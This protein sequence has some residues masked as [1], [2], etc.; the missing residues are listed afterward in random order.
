MN[1]KALLRPQI[2]IAPKYFHFFFFILGIEPWLNKTSACDKILANKAKKREAKS[3]EGDLNQGTQK[4]PGTRQQDSSQQYVEPGEESVA[5]SYDSYTGLYSN[6]GY[7]NMSVFESNGSL[8]M[9]YGK[10]NWV[11]QL[12]EWETTNTTFTAIGLDPIWY[13]NRI[14]TFQFTDPE[15]PKAQALTARFEWELD[16]VFRKNLDWNNPPPLPELCE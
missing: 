5:P 7:G 6:Y 12:T 11:W 16:P 14:V 2:K 13:D 4:Q 3:V 8:F 10:D 15:L 9:T 1:F